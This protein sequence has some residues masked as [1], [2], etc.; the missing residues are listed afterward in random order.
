MFKKPMPVRWNSTYDAMVDVYSNYGDPAKLPEFNSKL[1]S[2]DPN[3]PAFKAADMEFIGEFVKVF[4]PI[5]S[6]SD[7]LQGEG[8]PTAK[9]HKH[10]GA[11]YI[12]PCV[13]MML[14]GLRPYLV[15]VT[16][17]TPESFKLK[18]CRPLALQLYNSILWR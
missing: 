7:V 2:V 12:I 8:G 1:R 13:L 10:M 17:M 5:A 6:W 11:G 9:L 14:K 15:P 3:L 4:R 18:Y 16:E